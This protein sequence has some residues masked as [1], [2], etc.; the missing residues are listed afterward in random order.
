[1]NKRDLV[2]TRVR[3]I[4]SVGRAPALQAGGHRFEPGI[5]H[6]APVR[7]SWSAGN[8]WRAAAD[9]T[10]NGTAARLFDNRIDRVTTRWH[11]KP[12]C[13]NCV[14]AFSEKFIASFPFEHRHCNSELLLEVNEFYGQAGKGAWWMPWHRKAMK[15]VANCDKPRRAV[16]R[17]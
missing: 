17:L 5:L 12:K 11:F 8:C 2:L 6:L 10:G 16:S 14:R 7:S 9:G 13:F 15:D 4:S 3:G 1:M